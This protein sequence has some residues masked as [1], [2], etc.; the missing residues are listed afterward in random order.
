MADTADLRR[1]AEAATEGPWSLVDKGQIG[2]LHGWMVTAGAKAAGILTLFDESSDAEYIT[3]WHPARAL[4][5]LK[6]IEAAERQAE[7][8]E[9]CVGCDLWANSG[10]HHADCALREWKEEK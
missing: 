10:Q 7:R 8:D 4:A 1:I 6:V 9:I 3:A 2:K 5:A